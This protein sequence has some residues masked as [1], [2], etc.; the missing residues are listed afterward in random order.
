L[1][2]LAFRRWWAHLFESRRHGAETEIRGQIAVEATIYQPERKIREE[3]PEMV[4]MRT[5]EG[6]EITTDLE[7][8]I[9]RTEGRIREAVKEGTMTNVEGV[10]AEMRESE[11]KVTAVQP[12]QSSRAPYF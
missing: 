8:I 11:R 2:Y 5:E 3:I 7:M 10:A 6:G 9:R 12:H 1:R 4:G